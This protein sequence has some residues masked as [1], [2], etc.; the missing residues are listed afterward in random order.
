M[1][2]KAGIFVEDPERPE[3]FR[4]GFVEEVMG[5]CEFARMCKIFGGK[6]V[7]IGSGE[8]CGGFVVGLIWAF[9]RSPRFSC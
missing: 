6:D 7:G 8:K 4:R 3:Q 5:F 9:S 2:K 1:E